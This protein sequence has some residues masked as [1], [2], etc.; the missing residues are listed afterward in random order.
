VPGVAGYDLYSERFQLVA[1]VLSHTNARA[2]IGLKL[3]RYREAPRNLYAVVIEPREFLVEIYARRNNWQSIRLTSGG[4][5]IDMPE[6]R[7]RCR[8]GDL[9]RGTPLDPLRKS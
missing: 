6:F 3:R 8:V 5:P 4:D 2:E 1:E 7:L 9:Y